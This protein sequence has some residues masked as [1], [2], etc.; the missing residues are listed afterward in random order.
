ML[1]RYRASDPADP[2]SQ[3]RRIAKR[4]QLAIGAQK[5]LLRQVVDCFPI[6][7]DSQNDRANHP[8]VSIVKQA[9]RLAV[10]RLR[11]GDK[12]SIIRT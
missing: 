4:S 2:W 5:A 3:Q 10:S 8:R 7:G 12:F 1:T 6:A 11:L 9:E